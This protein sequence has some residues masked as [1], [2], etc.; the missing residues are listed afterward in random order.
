M[1]KEAEEAG[2][3]VL[4]SLKQR[5]F[6]SAFGSFDP[7]TAIANYHKVFEEPEQMQ[8]QTFDVKEFEPENEADVQE[9]LAA[10]FRAGVI[11]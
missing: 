4:D 7:Q 1:T 8:A 10:A 5:V 11:G 6:A 2:E 9:M 3:S